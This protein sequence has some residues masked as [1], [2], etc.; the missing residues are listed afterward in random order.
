[1]TGAAA[2]SGG[3]ATTGGG[4]PARAWAFAPGEEMLPGLR[5]IALLG[6]GRH[7]ETWLAWDVARWSAVA[8]K[9]PHPDEVGGGGAALARERRAVAEATH[10]GVQRLL[11]ARLD[12]SPPHLVFEYLEG[13]TLAHVLD[14]DGPFDPVDVVL[15][16]AQLAAALAYL[17]D[18]LG[19]V[20]LD[21]K[22]GNAVL[23]DG[24]AVLIDLGIARPAG[25]APPDGVLRGSPPYMAPEQLRRAPAAPSMD[26]F[27]LGL[28]MY[29]L[30]TGVAPY[31]DGRPAGRPEPQLAGRP[32]KRA[33]DLSPGIPERLDDLIW[34]LIDPDPRGRPAT[35]RATLAELAGAL[36][37]GVDPRERPWPAWATGLLPA[38]GDAGGRGHPAADGGGA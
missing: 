9:L 7:C 28:V 3:T 6:D 10:P 2:R 32:A 20:H 23:R 30:A 13:P 27:A 11:D 31:A 16:G 36:P 37:A 4:A 29:E 18:R 17:H 26:L 24:R 38:R 33:G 19:L 21:L 15:V 1:V 12:A 14:Q 22:P 35:A 25:E 5:A 34:R 8:V